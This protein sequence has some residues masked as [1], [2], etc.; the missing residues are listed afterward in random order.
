MELNVGN[1]R[2][3]APLYENNIKSDE[4]DLGKIHDIYMV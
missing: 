3:A 1:D 2:A 4:I